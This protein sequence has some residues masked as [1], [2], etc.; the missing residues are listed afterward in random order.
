LWVCCKVTGLIEEMFAVF[1][2]IREDIG[3]KVLPEYHY[4]A[5]NNHY[6]RVGHVHPL[7]CLPVTYF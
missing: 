7:F 6:V 4:S 2:R 5:E 1:F 3:R